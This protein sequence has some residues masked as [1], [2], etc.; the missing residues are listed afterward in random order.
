MRENKGFPELILPTPKYLF[1][2]TTTSS[3]F[4]SEPFLHLL[5][6]KVLKFLAGV[7]FVTSKYGS[8]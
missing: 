5:Y 2:E 6:C 4:C 1:H 3:P 7:E 8:S